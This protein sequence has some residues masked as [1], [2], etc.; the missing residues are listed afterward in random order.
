MLGGGHPALLVGVEE[1]EGALGRRDARLQ[2]VRH[3]GDLS[4]RLGELARVLDERGR[5][6][7]GQLTRGDAQAADDGDQHVGQVGDEVH[8]RHDDARNELRAERGLVQRVVTL[9][10]LLEHDPVAAEGAH[11]VETRERLLDVPVERAGRRPLRSN[12]FWEREPMTP[13]ITPESGMEISAISASCHETM[14]IMMPMP[15]TVRTDW[16]SCENACC[17]AVWML[18]TS[19]VTRDIR[20]PR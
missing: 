14:N 2:H 7:E 15:I 17:S 8:R 12:S 11:Q 9:V 5:V 4:D 10:E 19:L 20:S 3:A 13:A 16:M 18:S 6:A 1:L